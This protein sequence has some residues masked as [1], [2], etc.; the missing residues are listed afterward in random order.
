L[1]RLSVE[2]LSLLIGVFYKAPS[3]Q[4]L[5]FLDGLECTV[6]SFADLI[7]YSEI[8]FKGDFIIL[9]RLIWWANFVVLICP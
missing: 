1:V 3:V 4:F 2:G 5:S 8:V 7:R 9:I 6:S